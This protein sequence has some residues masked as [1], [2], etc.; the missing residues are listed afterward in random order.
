MK[1]FT[2]RSRP[3]AARRGKNGV[4]EEPDVEHEVRSMGSVLNPKLTG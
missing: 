3:T 1:A 2:A 4:R